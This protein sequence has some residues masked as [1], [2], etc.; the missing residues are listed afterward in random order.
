MRYKINLYKVS[1]GTN[2]LGVK[3][4]FYIS[5]RKS[6]GKR[7]SISVTVGHTEN[8]IDIEIVEREISKLECALD[9]ELGLLFE[10]FWVTRSCFRGHNFGGGV[11]YPL[12]KP[13]LKLRYQKT[14]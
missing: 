4:E 10:G 2:S 1:R 6:S 14:L 12:R 11:N 7:G 9:F 5:S 8:F 13:P 3:V